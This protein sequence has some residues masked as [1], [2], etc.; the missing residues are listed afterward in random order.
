[1][2]KHIEHESSYNPPEQWQIYWIKTYSSTRDLPMHW[3]FKNRYTSYNNN[4]FECR[5][6]GIIT[7]IRWMMYRS[8]SK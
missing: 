1:M 7:N 6:M 4:C 8:I 2:I 5:L 3:D